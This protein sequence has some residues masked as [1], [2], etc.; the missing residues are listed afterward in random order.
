MVWSPIILTHTIS[1][2][3]SK[4][5]RL[6]VKFQQQ[7]TIL[8]VQL[9]TNPKLEKNSSL[10]YKIA[11]WKLPF[12]QAAI[13]FMYFLHYYGALFFVLCIFFCNKNVDI[14]LLISVTD[15]ILCNFVRHCL[16][17][18]YTVTL[19]DCFTS[20]LVNLLTNS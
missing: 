10:R 5:N 6:E 11:C 19:N 4:T 1:R 20:L 12:C 7:Q 2:K 17:F 13:L 9:M 15:L 18:T 3:S 14:F 8:L 16:D